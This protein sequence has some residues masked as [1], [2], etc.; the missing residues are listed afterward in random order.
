MT[1]NFYFYKS[2]SHQKPTESYKDFIPTSNMTMQCKIAAGFVKKHKSRIKTKY[3]NEF[4]LECTRLPNVLNMFKLLDVFEDLR[5]D[6]SAPSL[7]AV[8]EDEFESIQTDIDSFLKEESPECSSYFVDYEETVQHYYLFHQNFSADILDRFIR[9]SSFLSTYGFMFS[10][11]LNNTGQQQVSGSILVDLSY[12]DNGYYLPIKSTPVKRNGKSRVEDKGEDQAASK[13]KKKRKKK[14]KNKDEPKDEVAEVDPESDN[15][16]QK[17]IDIIDKSIIDASISEIRIQESQSPELSQL[18]AFLSKTVSG[19]NFNQEW[20]LPDEKESAQAC[21]VIPQIVLPD[22]LDEQK[23][24]KVKSEIPKKGVEISEKVLKNPSCNNPDR[25]LGIIKNPLDKSAEVDA[26]ATKKGQ[27]SKK[28]SENP[29]TNQIAHP[30]AT[31]SD[32]KNSKSKKKADDGSK[33]FPFPYNTSE[34]ATISP[35]FVRGTKVSVFSFKNVIYYMF[36][37]FREKAEYDFLQRVNNMVIRDKQQRCIGA[38]AHMPR[39]LEYVTLEQKQEMMNRILKAKECLTKEFYESN[40]VEV[41]PVKTKK[42]KKK[43]K[44]K[45]VDSEDGIE[46]HVHANVVPQNQLPVPDKTDSVDKIEIIN[47]TPSDLRCLSE[48]SVMIISI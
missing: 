25:P 31:V 6:F 48:K 24:D 37:S 26:M 3:L 23:Y 12:R 21:E 17:N 27:K 40:G 2:D 13:P 30:S 36:K 9:E 39:E 33:N 15:A 18:T 46:G 38:K 1:T 44:T 5:S 19:F 32:S 47:P 10:D 41:P 22:R 8:H 14:N 45:A 42:K 11:S 4:N 34:L 7:T 16:V 35:P 29:K 20:K 43:K 28:A